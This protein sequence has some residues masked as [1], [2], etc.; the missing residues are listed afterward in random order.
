MTVSRILACACWLI[1]W[2]GLEGCATTRAT[3]Y[4]TLTPKLAATTNEASG[5]RASIGPFELAEYLNRPQMVT[6]GA[7][8]AVALEEFHRWAEPL[9]DLFVRTLTTNVSRQLG[10]DGIYAFPAPRKID[11]PVRVGGIV[12]RFDVD[13]DGRAILEVQWTIST[14][15]NELTQT[16]RRTRYE[17][18]A[19]EI[20]NFASRADALGTT[21]GSFALDIA[22]ALRA[23]P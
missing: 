20:E 8:S 23:L 18:V 7:G 15:E 12:Q 3:D 21:L 17:T 13:A 19:E 22:V 16:V 1:I 14:R 2:G 6:R 10:A 5:I 4:Y 9:E 11:V